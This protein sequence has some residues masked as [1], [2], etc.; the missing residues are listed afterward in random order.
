MGNTA[1]DVAPYDTLGYVRVTWD[2]SDESAGWEAWR[3]Y[4]RDNTISGSWVLVEEITVAA[5][6]YTVDDY[7]APANRDLDWAVVEV[8][9]GNVEGSYTP[10]DG[11]PTGTNYWLIDNVA[12]AQSFR[13][14]H[15]TDDTF[16]DE[17][18]EETLE[19]IGRGR[20]KDF[21]TRWGWNGSLDCEFFAKNGKTAL[22]QYLEI[23]TLKESQ[24]EAYLRT[25]FGDVVKISIGKISYDRVPGVGTDH[26]LEANISYEEIA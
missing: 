19:L 7:L 14:E 11:D 3:V 22:D 4:R 15:V 10:V 21:G 9:S 17:Y 2:N 18:E 24:N 8:T 23:K 16:D 26:R 5:A 1:V 13:L 6:S 20:K 12:S 25:P